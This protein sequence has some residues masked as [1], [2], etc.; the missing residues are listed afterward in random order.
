[1]SYELITALTVGFEALTAVDRTVTAGL[2]R[3]LGGLAA[4]VADHIIHLTL[5]ATVVAVLGT[6]R[7]AAGGAAAGLVLEALVS[8]EL[9]LRSGE[10]ELGAALTAS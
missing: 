7:G 6:T 10:N 8:I 4:A 1:M 2:E 9:L 3:N 5:A